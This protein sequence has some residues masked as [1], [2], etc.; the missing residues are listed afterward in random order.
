M[1]DCMTNIYDMRHISSHGADI[2]SARLL[3]VSDLAI[4]K[5]FISYF[6]PLDVLKIYEKSSSK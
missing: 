3:N 2:K 5:F 6:L 4:S 1:V